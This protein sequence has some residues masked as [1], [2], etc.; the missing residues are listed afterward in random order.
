MKLVLSRTKQAE[1]KTFIKIHYFLWGSFPPVV[2]GE[3]FF[4]A[5]LFSHKVAHVVRD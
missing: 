2:V 5:N 3:F 1:N 4:I